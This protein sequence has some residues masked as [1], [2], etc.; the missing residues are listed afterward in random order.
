MKFFGRLAQT[1]FSRDIIS[2]QSNR[3]LIQ[4]G[5]STIGLFIP[6]FFFEEFGESIALVLLFYAV[7]WGVYLF[8][9]V[10][11]AKLLTRFGSRKLLLIALPFLALS[12]IAVIYKEQ[13]GGIWGMIIVFTVLQYFFRLFYW[14]PYHIDVAVFTDRSQRGK[15]LSSIDSLSTIIMAV[16]PFIGAIIISH[17]GYDNVFYIAVFF[18]ILS[19]IPLFYVKD[20]RETFTFGYF[21]TWKKL[22]SKENRN[23]LIPFM[24]FGVQSGVGLVIWPIFV[25]TVVT[26]DYVTVGF[27]ALVTVVGAVILKLVI[28]DLADRW[29]KRKLL[30]LTSFLNTT[31][32]VAKI[33]V[34]TGFQIFIADTYHNFGKNANRIAFDVV[35]Y[36]QAA[37]NGSYID[38]YTVLKEISLNLGRVIL[39]LVSVVVIS[40][41]GI[42]A[43]FALAAVS[44]VFMTFLVRKGLT[45]VS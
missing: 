25:F 2:L 4:I 19:M 45:H 36:E 5:S 6:I 17:A 10:W 7:Q 28:G 26:G 16:M 29:S 12:W 18:Y 43:A 32:W 3:L 34:E 11:G 20:N 30:H 41:W 9:V 1:R 23:I 42:S 33:F 37:D 35:A 24:S 22:F 38:E 8:T 15:Q 14:L 39:L 13:I 31:G 44:S 27:I 21:E 40:L